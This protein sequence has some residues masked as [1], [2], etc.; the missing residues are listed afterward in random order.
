MTQP[1][2]GITRRRLLQGGLL[3]A[4][5]LSIPGVLSACSSAS[6][7][8]STATTLA[9]KGGTLRA[10][11]LGATNETLNVNNTASDAD[12]TRINAIF[13]QLLLVVG[14]KIVLSAAESVTPNADGSVWT[15]K[16]Q[17][18]TF[19]DGKPVTADD[20]AWSFNFM[21]NPS[22]NFGPT[23][24]AAFDLDHMTSLDQRT[25]QVPLTSPRG[26]FLEVLEEV[27]Y[28]FPEGLSDF[29]KP[30]GSGPFQVVSYT[31]GQSCVM[32][33]FSQY[34]GGSPLLDGLLVDTVNDA[35]SALDAVKS[36]QLDYA[37]AISPTS[38][39][40]EANNRNVQIINGGTANGHALCWIMNTT[41]PPFDDDRV[42]QAMA[43]A[44]NRQAL[45]NIAFGQYGSVGN[46]VIGQG[47]PGFDTSLKPRPYDPAMARQ[48]LAAAGQ[49]DLSFA[50]RTFDSPP[51]ALAATQLWVQ[52]LAA[53]GVTATLDTV[54]V[55]DR[56][57]NTEQSAAL[58]QL[59]DFTNRSTIVHVETFMTP[60]VP[61][62]LDGG[63]SPAAFNALVAQSQT[64]TNPATRQGIIDQVSQMLYNEGPYVVWGYANNLDAAAKGVGGVTES[65]GL[66]LFGKASL[67]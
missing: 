32:S 12:F 61:V 48:L 44:T 38:A 27:C 42:R 22:G 31:P 43:Y 46:D 2:R 66:P 58:I 15:I 51:G 5:G 4:A 33:A 64:A 54:P 28:V 1:Y 14:D 25:L 60:A 9:K 24:F 26:D 17:D 57:N 19:H 6:S 30:I 8:S 62:G 37:V 20:V 3:G 36:G 65:Q 11:V 59:G 52:Q 29:S 23:S 47:L 16:L 34:W 63:Y 45:I 21:A 41:K 13:D 53:V 55:T 7:S 67:G 18:A 10:G 39:R 56:Y 50:V 40:V 49:S 35:D